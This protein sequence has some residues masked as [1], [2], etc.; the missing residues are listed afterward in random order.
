[1][2]DSATVPEPSG[3]ARAAD[4]VPRTESRAIPGTLHR[5]RRAVVAGIEL[6]LAALAV[7]GAF[8]LWS[9]G[10]TTLS[11]S[12]SDGLVLTSTRYHG[13]WI[14]G[15][16]ALGGLA[17]LLV[18]DAARELMLAVRTRRVRRRRPDREPWPGFDEDH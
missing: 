17:A 7:W 3:A 12:T 9:R 6:L 16:I 1:M 13:N 5:P 2:D 15:A 18:L 10:I 14:A 11:V 4:G 8:Q